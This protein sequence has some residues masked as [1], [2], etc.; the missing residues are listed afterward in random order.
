MEQEGK[1]IFTNVS[2]PSSE[3]ITLVTASAAPVEAGIM[4]LLTLR[5]PRQSLR[6]G[7]STVF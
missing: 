1:G 5:P 6:V 2:L 7:P 4:L 3:G